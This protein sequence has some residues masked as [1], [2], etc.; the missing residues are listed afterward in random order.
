[1]LT[2][3]WRVLG[4]KVRDSSSFLLWREVARVVSLVESETCMCSWFMSMV[5]AVL[6]VRREV[7]MTWKR[8]LAGMVM[9]LSWYPI[10][11]LTTP[12]P[13]DT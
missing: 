8:V 12:D 11:V 7:I 4:T 3:K 9:V 2:T 5:A 13:V 10:L 6:G 1:M